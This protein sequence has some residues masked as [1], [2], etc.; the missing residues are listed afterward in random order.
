MVPKA[1]ISAAFWPIL[2]LARS[3]WYSSRNFQLLFRVLVFMGPAGVIN[4]LN[5]ARDR[6]ALKVKALMR[7]SIDSRQ[8]LQ[9]FPPLPMTSR[10]RRGTPLRQRYPEVVRSGEAES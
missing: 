2:G 6:A 8:R 10:R 9:R 3:G 5:A 1:W 4:L 7:Y